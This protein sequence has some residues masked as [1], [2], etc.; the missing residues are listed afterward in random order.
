[1]Y[2]GMLS[3][4]LNSLTLQGKYA[5]GDTVTFAGWDKTKCVSLDRLKDE[6]NF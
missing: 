4:S 1:M 3:S 2:L 6:S 5:A